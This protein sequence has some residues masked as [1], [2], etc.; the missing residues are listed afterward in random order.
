M[1]PQVRRLEVVD[2]L[3]LRPVVA[4]PY[5][6]VDRP[7]PFLVAAFRLEVERRRPSSVWVASPLEAA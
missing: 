6:E 3:P 7:R 4:L 5:R 2:R 1:E